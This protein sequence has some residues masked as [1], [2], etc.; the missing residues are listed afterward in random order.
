M[1][2]SVIVPVFEHW[3]WVP[4]LLE[5]L[6]RQDFPRERFE[7]LLVDNGSTAFTPPAALSE[8]TRVL[9]CPRPGSYAARNHGVRSASGEWLAFTDADCL[10]APGWLSAFDIASREPGR[11]LLAGAVETV[12]SSAS[13][14]IYE[15][16]DMVR[17]IPQ[18]RYVKRGYAATANLVVER[19]LAD[20]LGGF[21]G[22]RYS[23]G[24][25]DF[26]RRARAGGADIAFVPEAVVRHR[27]RVSWPAV[28]T[29]A[30]R[31]KGAQ[32]RA[33]LRRRRWMW[34]VRTLLPPVIAIMRL[35]R[36]K[37]FSP[38]ERGIAILVQ[39]RVWMAE[40]GEL[41]RLVIRR[42]PERR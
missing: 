27:A 4:E 25:A 40:M 6:E 21:D 12:R 33:A 32:L 13:P 23:G 26:C 5:C 36:A 29:K 7:V 19:G 15:I 22:R 14:G 16:Y 20:E 28:S 30:R 1:K 18:A 3:H 41:I 34:A 31:I 35:A 37:G 11:R 10:P 24:D 9:E 38:R 8:N 17:G 2:F 39:F 42:E